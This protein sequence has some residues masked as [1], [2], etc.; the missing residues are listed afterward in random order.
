M[1]EITTISHNENDFR[2]NTEDS[3]LGKIYNWTVNNTDTFD[4]FLYDYRTEV[5]DSYHYEDRNFDNETE[6]IPYY[7]DNY[8]YT[9]FMY[10]AFG[11]ERPIY[12]YLWVA[13]VILMVLVNILVMWV[14][15][16][17]KMRNI[18]NILL[19]AIAISDSMT[20]LVT[21]PTYI[22]VYGNLETNSDTELV[23]GTDP[24]F[25]NYENKPDSQYGNSSGILVES[26]DAYILSK[27]LCDA[28]MFSTFFLSKTFH[29][30]S[31]WLTLFLG[32]H[33]YISV[34]YPFK[35]QVW[36]TITK[37]VIVVVLVSVFAPVLHTYHLV[38]KKT[39]DG[40][41]A[42][43]LKDETGAAY[44]HIWIT[45]FL[46]HL[47]PCFILTVT[48]VL[49]V[50]NLNK[51]SFQPTN[52]TRRTGKEGGSRV[53]RTVLA[54][55]ILFLIPEVPYG[56]FLLYTSIIGQLNESSLNDLK[57]NRVIHAGYEIALVLSFHLNFYVYT[58]FNKK[59]RFHLR[60]TFG[61]FASHLN[62]LRLST[63]RSFSSNERTKGESTKH[64]S[65]SK[66]SKATEMKSLNQSSDCQGNTNTQM[67]TF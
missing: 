14:L 60:K 55:M 17:K 39:I 15:L 12:L 37:T 65:L 7:D 49:F 8:E 43:Q 28:F 56:L 64:E 42:W 66:D 47:I 62:S 11:F 41:C 9:E 48:T 25:D 59:F 61:I 67:T 2:G 51:N 26:K 34:T 36:F 5:Y 30:I 35:K 1:E 38:H 44:A 50:R 58:F 27:S 10:E 3:L 4:Q 63:R 18:T 23:H 20:G 33:R 57:R 46:R 19:V 13:L 52:S 16:Q 29:T 54:I 24:Y 45:L 32:I 6:G 53:S 21:L 22:I 40:F 31:I